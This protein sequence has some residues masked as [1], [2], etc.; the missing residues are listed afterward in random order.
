V[1]AH[2]AADPNDALAA[3][4]PYLRMVGTT[5]GGWVM[6][7]QAAAARADAASDPYAAAKLATAR[8]Y[9]HELLPQARGLLAAVEAGAGLVMSVPAD[10]L[11]S[12]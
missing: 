5:L 4:T 10:D 6:A 8:F 2:G 1:L 7:R 9:C 3:A 12:R 11:V